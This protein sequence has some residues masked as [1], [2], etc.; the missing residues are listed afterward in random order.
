MQEILKF[1]MMSISNFKIYMS[2]ELRIYILQVLEN[3]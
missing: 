2:I 3:L 1:T